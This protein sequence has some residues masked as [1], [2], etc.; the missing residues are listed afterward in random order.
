M[1]I[2]FDVAMYTCN[3]INFSVTGY[4]AISCQMMNLQKLFVL[5]SEHILQ[6]KLT[7]SFA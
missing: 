7:L 5:L 2:V 1:F 3:V 4:G 6:I